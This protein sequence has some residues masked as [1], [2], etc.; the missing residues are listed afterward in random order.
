MYMCVCVKVCM[1]AYVC[2]YLWLCVYTS[3]VHEGAHVYTV[4]IEG[5]GYKLGYGSSSSIHLGIL[6]QGNSLEGNSKGCLVDRLTSSHNGS[7][8]LCLLIHGI[9]S[10]YRHAHHIP[11]HGAWGW[12]SGSPVC[13]PTLTDCVLS[14][15]I[16]IAWA[17]SYS[18]WQSTFLEAWGCL[19][20]LHG[21]KI[22][23]K[24][25]GLTYIKGWRTFIFSIS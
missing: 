3:L 19:L 12:N 24:D 22:A 23:A 15:V 7:S 14:P 21:P 25:N 9:I 13:K 11:K 1:L 5:R 20:Y 2:A 16:G 6:R 10:M 8:W 4:Y 18:F 17:A